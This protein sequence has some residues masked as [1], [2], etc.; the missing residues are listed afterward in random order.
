MRGGSAKGY[1]VGRP[2]LEAT[3][4]VAAHF[5]MPDVREVGLHLLGELLAHTYGNVARLAHD[6]ALVVLV[7]RLHDVRQ[8]QHR[9]PDLRARQVVE[10]R[11][12]VAPRHV[13]ERTQIPLSLRVFVCG[14]QQKLAQEGAAVDHDNVLRRHLRSRAE[15]FGRRL[16]MFQHLTELAHR[17]DRLLS[18]G[19]RASEQIRIRNLRHRVGVDV[20][21]RSIRPQIRTDDAAVAVEVVDHQPI[22]GIGKLGQR[23]RLTSGRLT[24][25]QDAWRLRHSFKLGH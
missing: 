17:I 1:L 15:V 12:V 4:A 5:K 25:D 11:T 7:S 21:V 20:N 10:D 24:A 6:L 8:H 23:A 19:A 2:G 18:G 16:P 9:R 14:Q 22:P 13:V 3:L